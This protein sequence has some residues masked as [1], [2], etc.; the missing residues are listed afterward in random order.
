MNSLVRT[1]NT[2]RLT[3]TR[4]LIYSYMIAFSINRSLQLY[5][6]LNHSNW[7]LLGSHGFAFLGG[8]G[9]TAQH[10][11]VSTVWAQT[12]QICKGVLGMSRET[13]IIVSSPARAGHDVATAGIRPF[14]VPEYFVIL[15]RRV[16]RGFLTNLP[17]RITC[18]DMVKLRIG[19]NARH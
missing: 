4:I 12:T 17:M 3:C 13:L 7:L 9:A 14:I 5:Y 16:L 19:V 10:S 2:Q 8:Y 1:F 18:L 11:L 6:M 15:F